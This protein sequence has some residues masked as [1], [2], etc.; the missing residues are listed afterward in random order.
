MV[1][2]VSGGCCVC[3]QAEKMTVD[4]LEVKE[5]LGLETVKKWAIITPVICRPTK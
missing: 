4:E 2:I 1:E 5:E 3:L